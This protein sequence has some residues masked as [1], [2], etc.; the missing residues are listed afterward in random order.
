MGAAVN[1]RY[2]EPTGKQVE[3][4]AALL[5]LAETQKALTARE[6]I[7]GLTLEVEVSYTVHSQRLYR[8]HATAAT[9][10][11]LTGKDGHYVHPANGT[12][13]NTAWYLALAARAA[14]TRRDT[15]AA[16]AP[17]EHRQESA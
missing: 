5:F 10:E 13:E 11:N 6:H 16:P 4:A 15:A 2:A 3:E 14:R 8:V 1:A 12:P 9:G 7:W 17:A